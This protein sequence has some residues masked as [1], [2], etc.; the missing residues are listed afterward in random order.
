MRLTEGMASDDWQLDRLDLDGYLKRLGGAASGVSASGGY[1]FGG[2][3]PEP[4]RARSRAA[5]T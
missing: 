4:R 1:V 2:A 5:P 3:T